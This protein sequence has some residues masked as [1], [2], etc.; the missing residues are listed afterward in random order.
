MRHRL[1]VGMAVLQPFRDGREPVR[2]FRCQR[3]AGALRLQSLRIV[4]DRMKDLPLVGVEQV[5]H[6][7][8]VG[9]GDRVGPRRHDPEMLGVAGDMQRRVLQRRGVARELFQRLV[10]VALA[11][12]VLP[13]EITALPHVGEAVAAAGLGHAFLEGVVLAA[14]VRLDGG[15]VIE[16]ST[17]VDEVLL[18]RGPFGEAVAFPLLDEFMRRHART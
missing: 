10:E 2:R 8:R 17:Q 14:P 1:A 18:R 3:G 16:Q 5:F 11:L 6:R 9:L 7:Q 15:R 12:L 13:G 4:E